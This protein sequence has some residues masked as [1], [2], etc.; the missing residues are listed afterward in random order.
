VDL[1]ER[2]A[3]LISEAEAVGSELSRGLFWS[4]TTKKTIRTEPVGRIQMIADFVLAPALEL[5]GNGIIRT[6]DGRFPDDAHNASCLNLS[7]NLDPRPAYWARLEKH[8]FDLLENLPSDWDGSADNW[9]PDDQLIATR[10]WRAAIKQEAERALV[11]S[12]RSLGT[13]TRAIGAVARV[14]IDFSDND[15]KPLPPRAKTSKKKSKATRKGGKK[16]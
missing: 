4:A 7:D 15:L 13:T 2:L 5:R 16:K 12:I 9:K 6:G 1:T 3:M 11:E 14:P 8:F 10:T